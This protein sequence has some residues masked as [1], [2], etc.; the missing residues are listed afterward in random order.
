[1]IIALRVICTLAAV[2]GAWI[3]LFLWL[4]YEQGVFAHLDTGTLI[5]KLSGTL[6]RAGFLFMCAW[7]AWS[8]PYLA[9]WF[10]WGAFLAFVVAGAGDQVFRFGVIDG[11]RNLI[12]TYYVVSSIHALVATVIW[13]LVRAGNGNHA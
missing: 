10:A 2:F 12:P 4:A 6:I 1:M 13:L 5:L 9:P 3:T 8:R 11:M 7:A